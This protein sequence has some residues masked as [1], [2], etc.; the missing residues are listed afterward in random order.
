MKDITDT[1]LPVDVVKVGARMAGIGVFALFWCPI[2]GIFVA[3]V[4]CQFYQAWRTSS[5]AQTQGVLID[6]AI[7]E[8]EA[9][10]NAP[11]SGKKDDASP[12][13]AYRYR[14][15][16]NDYVGK[17]L[18]AAAA[19]REEGKKTAIED[20]VANM[21]AGDSVIV[22]YNPADPSDALLDRTLDSMMYF[23]VLFLQPFVLIGLGMIYMFFSAPV[24]IARLR[25]FLRSS[26][27]A[28][29]DIPG[30]GRL[31]Q[32]LQGL[33]I[34]PR[35]TFTSL[36][37]SFAGGYGLT[38]FLGVFGAAFIGLALAP[39]HIAAI[40]LGI[41]SGAAAVGLLCA[42]FMIR[43][44]ARKAVVTLDTE[45]GTLAVQSARRDTTVEVRDIQAWA[46][47]MVD[48]S[49][50]FRRS[51]APRTAPLLM[52]RMTNTSSV[53]VHLFAG[54][55]NA[56]LAAMKVGQALARLTKHAL[57]E[58][59]D[60]DVDAPRTITEALGDLPGGKDNYRDLS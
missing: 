47:R 59:A 52:A 16:G 29:W 25:R 37:M 17:R 57:V 21:K 6:L 51:D 19:M 15:D 27:G 11:A 34:R 36:V 31:E 13:L 3:F 42:V 2:T 41:L 54:S 38:C 26:I 35:P 44:N 45:R 24:A 23:M 7:A 32:Q 49:R 20:R 4:A 46:I 48:V 60:E 55:E 22:Y 53:P 14:V 9:D 40:S 8:P 33:V 10:P 30:W 5:F 28:T 1:P 43:A 12:P 18:Q 39:K 50:Q 58:L 56:P